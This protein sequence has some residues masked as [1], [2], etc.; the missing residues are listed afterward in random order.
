LA[1][2]VAVPETE[3]INPQHA[4]F[5]PDLGFVPLTPD[6]EKKMTAL[7]SRQNGVVSMALWRSW[8]C[9]LF[10]C[11]RICLKPHEAHQIRLIKT[12]R[13][14]LAEVIYQ[15]A[16][17]DEIWRLFSNRTDICHFS[18]VPEYLRVVRRRICRQMD[19]NKVPMFLVPTARTV[20]TE[21]SNHLRRLK[22]ARPDPPRRHQPVKSKKKRSPK[23][24]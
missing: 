10:G 19:Q 8:R 20:V 4:F 7:D 16:C 15:R 12:E 6:E 22:K 3:V 5:D 13:A 9:L 2:L 1:A 24:K 17:R 18:E 23:K 11:G 14:E 21:L